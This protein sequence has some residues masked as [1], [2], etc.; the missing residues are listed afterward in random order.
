MFITALCIITPNWKQSK[1]SGEIVKHTLVY[2]YQGVLLR[3]KNKSAKHT[4]T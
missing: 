2:M 4:T 1:F 3:N